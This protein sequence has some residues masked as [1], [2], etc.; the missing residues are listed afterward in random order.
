MGELACLGELKK[1]LEHLI[2]SPNDEGCIEEKEKLIEN[3]CRSVTDALR[4]NNLTGYKG[5]ELEGHAYAVNNKI[6]DNNIRNL[7]IL[8]GV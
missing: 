1:Q 7:H 4:E 2:S 8:Y 6:V 3:I 5:D